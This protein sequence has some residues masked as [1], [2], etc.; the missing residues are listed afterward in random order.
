MSHA[1]NLVGHITLGRA[2]QD[3]RAH[4]FKPVE[5]RADGLVY[6]AGGVAS[7]QPFILAH[8]VDSGASV[9]I[10]PAPNVS[11]VVCAR[12]VTV[13]EYLVHADSGLGLTVGSVASVRKLG[14]AL[15]TVT[16]S[17]GIGYAL[18]TA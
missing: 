7:S 8:P 5:L 9:A 4:G 11:P 17:G 1:I 10:T 6:L 12:P 16:A 14:V 2:A 3:L 18:L 15:T 13:G